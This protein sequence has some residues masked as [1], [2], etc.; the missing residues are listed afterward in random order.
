MN[1][2]LTAL[3][4]EGI[5]HFHLPATRRYL[6]FTPIICLSVTWLIANG[7]QMATEPNP[8]R[9]FETCSHLIM[10]INLPIILLLT[11]VYQLS[12]Q[13]QEVEDGTLQYLLT[14]PVGIN[15]VLSVKA[16]VTVIVWYVFSYACLEG[17]ILLGNKILASRQNL[18]LDAIDP[19]LQ[20]EEHVIFHQII[21]MTPTILLL[22]FT[23]GIITS[24]IVGFVICMLG[25]VML[26]TPP[27]IW[28]F[29]TY[30]SKSTQIL[31]SIRSKNGLF[32]MSDLFM[33][34]S[35]N[36][37]VVITLCVVAIVIYNRKLSQSN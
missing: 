31:N 25:V 13:Q 17:S 1:T 5:K 12:I 20:N 21:L 15:V 11:S 6:I 24:R 7:L 34:H 2:I 33:L 32:T 22:H 37:L 28:N 9:I 26:Y 29:F 35:I 14:S 27:S 23:F 36:L 18:S 16:G 30:P 8:V 3:T 10:L 19:F 4:T